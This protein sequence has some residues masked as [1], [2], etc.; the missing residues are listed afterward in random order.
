M[1]NDQNNMRPCPDGKDECLCKVIDCISK[2]GP[3]GCT[4]CTG[5]TG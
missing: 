2:T 3:T 4:G 5:P 1:N